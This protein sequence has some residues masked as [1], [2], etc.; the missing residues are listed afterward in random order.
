MLQRVRGGLDLGQRPRRPAGATWGPHTEIA[1]AAR[2]SVISLTSL[3]GAG[4]VTGSKH[5]LEC[6]GRRLLVDCGLF[7]GLKKLREM[8]WRPLPVRPGSIDG[9]I[10]THAHLDHCGYLPKLVKDGFRG[11]IYASAATRGVAEIILRDSAKLQESDAESAN[12]HGYSKHAPAL[13]LY[14]ARDAEQALAHFCDMPFGRAADL[15][16]GAR[17]TLR[18]AGHI[19][20]AATAEVAWGGARV[21]FSGDLGRYGDPTMVDPEP[22]EEA[23][24][25]VV[26]STYGDRL[27]DNRDPT[28]ALGEVIE[29][30]TAR[31]GTVIIPAFAVG[32]AQS[33]LHHL[34]RLKAAGRLPLTPIYL[35]SPMAISATELLHRH[36]EDH[37]LPPE[38]CDATCAVA[39][40]VRDVEMSKKV[41]SNT[42]P[43]VIVAASGMATGGRVLHHIKAYAP[44]R[45]NTIL[46]SGF[47]AAGTRGRAMVEGAREVKIHG[48]WI[49]VEAEVANLGMLSAHADASEILRW[50]SGFRRPPRKTFIVHGEPH[51]S[52]ALRL[53]I[54][55]R[56]GWDCVIP[57]MMERHEL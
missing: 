26:E 10:L 56:L 52:D 22:A 37:R 54:K 9:V 47:Q 23:D 49:P 36:R 53:Q 18:R 27:H 8:N 43:K 12:R 16:A 40:Y 17:V 6:G 19:L 35:D 7:Q 24:V 34:W 21:V 25:V 28:E 42:M 2:G 4:T 41:T 14:G 30:T 55:D 1:H 20:G 3:G 15:A 31:G 29:R 51:A 38:A 39:T 50:L 44:D 45:R 5:L 13:P 11:E 32:R 57:E 46:F 48:Q 33:L